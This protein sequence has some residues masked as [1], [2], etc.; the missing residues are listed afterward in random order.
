VGDHAAAEAEPPMVTAMEA[1]VIQ[2]LQVGNHSAAAKQ[3]VEQQAVS[4]SPVVESKSDVP[5]DPQVDEAKTGDETMVDVEVTEASANEVSL[6]A[7]STLSIPSEVTDG[8]VQGPE[9]VMN[10]NENANVDDNE[11]TTEMDSP[12]LP[13]LTQLTVE[14]DEVLVEEDQLEGDEDI[15]GLS[16]ATSAENPVDESATKA[17]A[18]PLLTQVPYELENDELSILAE[19]Q[20]KVEKEGES[21]ET[22]LED[23]LE[24]PTEAEEYE[25]AKNPNTLPVLTQPGAE[26][27]SDDESTQE[28]GNSHLENKMQVEETPPGEN[29]EDPSEATSQEA[30][31][32]VSFE[33]S[34]HKRLGIVGYRGLYIY[35]DEENE[36]ED[37]ENEG[38]DEDNTDSYVPLTQVRQ[39]EDP[40]D[41]TGAQVETNEGPRPGLDYESDDSMEE[42]LC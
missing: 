36:E 40:I 10:D 31:K 23:S 8:A 21:S 37:E 20:A 11:D 6:S 39:Y 33:E 12:T 41:D 32:A 24:S 5:R 15:P 38:E 30:P 18:A 28:E 35:S 26:M 9:T 2:D 25:S 1:S 17:P 14:D 7:D 42:L 3:D 16:E 19:E 27:D 22:L 34:G 29:D 4:N 13:M